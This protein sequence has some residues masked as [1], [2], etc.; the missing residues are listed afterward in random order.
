MLRDVDIVS[1]GFPK[2]KKLGE[3]RRHPDLPFCDIRTATENL[4]AANKI[5]LG[6]FGSIYKLINL[7]HSEVSRT[8]LLFISRE[9][10]DGCIYKYN[11]KLYRLELKQFDKMTSRE[12]GGGDDFS[13]NRR[14]YKSGV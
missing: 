14:I 13:D 11:D 9:H 8:T 10:F 12:E 7:K 6:G 1:E 5:G 3:S 4:F 2:E